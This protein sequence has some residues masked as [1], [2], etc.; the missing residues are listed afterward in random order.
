MQSSS[1]RTRAGR[2]WP[3]RQDGR[4]RQHLLVTAAL[5]SGLVPATTAAAVLPTGEPPPAPWL[6]PANLTSA[7]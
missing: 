4:L 7:T 5:S 2:R 6:H 3:R 1:P